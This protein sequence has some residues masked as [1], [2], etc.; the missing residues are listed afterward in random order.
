MYG[1]I[2]GTGYEQPEVIKKIMGS[3]AAFLMMN[4]PEPMLLQLNLNG[5]F[6][7]AAAEQARKAV[8]QA[9]AASGYGHCGAGRPCGTS[10][11]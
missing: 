4:A 10:A 3:E 2:F 9:S 7:V 8:L 6:F 5:F 11:L 1:L